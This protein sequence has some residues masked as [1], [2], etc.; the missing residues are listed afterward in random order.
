MALVRYNPWHEM[1]SLQHQLNRL[2]DDALTNDSWGE[3]SNLSK[4]PAAELTQT[5]EALHLKLEVPGMEAKD[6]DIQVMADR[7]SISGERK[8]ETKSE[9]DGTTHSEFRYGKFSRVI[10]LPIKI[11][12]TKVTA[13]Y[14]DGIL[15]LNLPKVE[16]EKN[17]VVKINLPEATA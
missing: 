14:K 11:N 2:F 17:K 12:N 5:D 16:E 8:S 15:H 7:V 9:T 10:P 4:I 1:S 13:E 3:W 6:L